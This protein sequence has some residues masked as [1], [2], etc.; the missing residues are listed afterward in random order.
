ML[1]LKFMFDYT[2]GTCIWSANQETADNFGG[3]GCIHHETLGVS[4]GLGLIMIDLC[5]EFDSSLDRSNPGGP[6]PWTEEHWLDFKERTRQVYED[7]VKEI[8]ETYKVE[9]W[10]DRKS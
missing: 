10:F 8:G 7:L 1:L 5:K 6:S 3:W 4:D 9:N 2:A